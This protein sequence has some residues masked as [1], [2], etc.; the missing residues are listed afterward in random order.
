LKV[1]RNI[2]LFGLV[3]DNESFCFECTPNGTIIIAT[4]TSVFSFNPITGLDRRICGGAQNVPCESCSG[5]LQGDPLTEITFQDIG[6]IAYL[7]NEWAVAVTDGQYIRQV[8]LT[9][10]MC[11]PLTA[12][13]SDDGPKESVDYNLVCIVCKSAPIT[14]HPMAQGSDH[15]VCWKC[16]WELD[17]HYQSG[18]RRAYPHGIRGIY[19]TNSK[20]LGKEIAEDISYDINSAAKIAAARGKYIFLI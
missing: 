17:R 11:L 2:K 8:P 3:E 18:Y 5:A 9:A 20:E 1:G 15:R 4:Q 16:R 12:T 10:E 19:R 6:S 14:G 7:P 13:I